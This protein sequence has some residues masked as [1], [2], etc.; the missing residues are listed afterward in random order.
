MSRSD[1][2]FILPVYNEAE[3]VGGVVGS[4]LKQYKYVVC[5]DDGSTDRSVQELL[6]TD[7]YLVQHPINMG[8][9]AALQTGI[10][11]AKQLPVKYFVTFDADGQHQLSDV[12]AM[13]KQIEKSKVDIVMGSRFLGRTEN[14]SL[15][16]R[17]IL[18]AAVK[19]TNRTSGLRLTD[20]HNGLRVFNRNVAET[21]K[22]TMPDMSHASEI[23]E[24][25]KKN[26]YRYEE[27]PVTIRYTDYSMS[28]GQSMINAV[29]IGFDLL[30]RRISR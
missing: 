3:V 12:K 6:S 24:L 15:M 30:L 14:M 27:V 11:F 4:I 1:T 25:I 22:I 5:V 17:V 20:T 2:V 9:G 10:D 7:A 26:Q 29:N 18:R 19:F 13:L 28:K 23:I 21:L 8:Q 16:K